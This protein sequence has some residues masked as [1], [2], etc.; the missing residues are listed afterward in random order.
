M[1]EVEV[2]DEVPGP[3]VGDLVGDHV[4]VGLVPGEEGGGGEGHAGVLHPAVCKAWRQDEDVVVPPDVGTTQLLCR[5][6][7]RLSLR[8]VER[9]LLHELLLGPDVCPGPD[10]A[11]L[12]RSD[13][14]GDQVR[15]DWNFL[16][17]F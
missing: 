1:L 14:D 17:E 3:G 10:L 2:G 9:G 12:H 13:C 4:G 5:L 15:L 6:Y 7:E 8:E 16:D 11:G